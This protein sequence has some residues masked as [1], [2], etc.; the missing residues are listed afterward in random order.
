MV[1]FLAKR[2]VW[3][4]VTLF[5]YLTV[6]FFFIDWWVP[7]DWAT[8]ILAG[9]PYDFSGPLPPPSLDDPAPVR[10]LGFVTGVLSGDLGVSMAGVAVGDIITETA[11]VTI[12]VFA[13]AAVIAYVLGELAGRVG[14]WHRNRATGSLIS[15]IGVISATIFPPFLVFLLVH[16]LRDPLWDLRNAMGL[17]VDSLQLWRDANLEPAE[18]LSLMALA[19]L[20]AVL[21]ALALRAYGHRRRLPLVAGLA[22]PVALAAAAA[23]MSLSGVGLFALDLLYRV[24]ISTAVGSGSPVLVLIGVVL[25]W[26]GQVMFMMRVGIEDERSEDYVLTA[27]GKGIGERMVRDRHVARNALAPV[28]A[29]SFLTFPT[30]IAGMVIVELELEV[31]GLSWAFFRAIEFQDIPTVMG[32]LVVLGL[33]GVFFRIV[34]DVAVAALDPRQR[35]GRV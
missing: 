4:V 23:G 26:F 3:A 2:L 7:N 15:V 20:G 17:P 33:L 21:V 6:L 18:V 28:V 29:G 22:F 9:E 19:V 13:A 1:G 30:V 14:A 27:R 10:Y 8:Q 12:L 32:V 35:Q 16:F 11:P 31:R 5:L 24:D 34:T 25:L